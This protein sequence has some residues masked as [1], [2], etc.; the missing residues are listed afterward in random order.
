M[1]AFDALLTLVLSAAPVSELRGAI[2]VAL[3]R[4][5]APATAFFLALAGNLLVIPVI[6]FV[7][8]VGERW[9]RRWNPAAKL[10]DWAFS[11]VRR[12]ER[13]IRRLGPFGLF[14]LVAIPLP[15]TGA[16]TGAF[17]AHLLSIPPRRAVP[18]IVIGVVVAG[19]L[20]LSA[21]L[22]LLRLFGIG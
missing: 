3:A 18:P 8:R 12:R 10:L 4:G 19:I 5:A 13:W 15:G 9:I 20:V 2:P 22:G 21:C 17:A 1:S 11:R 7:L 16:W 6:L 14:L